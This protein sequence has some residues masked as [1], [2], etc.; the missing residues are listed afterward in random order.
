MVKLRLRRKGRKKA[1]TY[2]IVAVDSRSRR[3]GDYLERIGYYDPMKQPSTVS[4]QHDRAI[5]WLNNGAQPTDIVRSLMSAD[6]LLLRRQMEF[7]GKTGEEIEAAIAKHRDLAIARYLKKQAARKA[8]K[9]AA[10]AAAA[11]APVDEAAPAPEAA[12]VEEPMN[13]TEDIPPAEPSAE[14]P[15]G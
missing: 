7:K 6:G 10:A 3:D 11:A 1:P 9:L 2:D 4:F 14:Q 5:Y 13:S 12:P 15:E 8:R